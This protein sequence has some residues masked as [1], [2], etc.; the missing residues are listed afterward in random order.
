MFEQ[1]VLFQG[2]DVIGV[3]QRN[4]GITVG[5]KES[6]NS[7]TS[8]VHSLAESIQTINSSASSKMENAMR[9]NQ[10]TAEEEKS[11]ENIS[12]TK[13]RSGEL[14]RD[15]LLQRHEEHSAIK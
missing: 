1:I 3:K 14:R 4:D 10:G 5:G 2:N 9:S 12:E 11:I 7:V 8:S 13:D 6:R 15:Q